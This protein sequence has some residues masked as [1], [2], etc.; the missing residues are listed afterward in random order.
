MG[1]LTFDKVTHVLYNR[2]LSLFVDDACLRDCFLVLLL[3][4]APARDI[5][6]TKSPALAKMTLTQT[7]GETGDGHI[8]LRALWPKPV[9]ALW[10]NFCIFTRAALDPPLI[11]ITNEEVLENHPDLANKQATPRTLANMQTNSAQ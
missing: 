8:F 4:S 5:I 11:L 9:H 1:K 3:A 6:S 2:G 10:R 7:F